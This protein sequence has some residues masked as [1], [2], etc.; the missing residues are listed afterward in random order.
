MMIE[1]IVN[2]I[3]TNGIGIVLIGYFIYRDFKFTEKITDALDK[4]NETL[5]ILTT[6]HGRDGGS[7]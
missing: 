1:D 4:V 3:M 5:T 6:Y 2:L 7:L